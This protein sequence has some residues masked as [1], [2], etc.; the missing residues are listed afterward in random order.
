MKQLLFLGF[1]SLNFFSFGQTNTQPTTTAEPVH[2]EQ[3]SNGSR[4]TKKVTRNKPTPPSNS[5][6]KRG[7]NHNQKIIIT[8]LSMQ[9]LF[10]FAFLL[11]SSITRAQEKFE[12][13]NTGTKYST[14]QI[15]AA[16]KNADFCGSFYNTKR[17][18]IKLDDGAE[19][20]L[21]SGV[22]LEQEGLKLDSSCLLS[23]DITFY[24][25]SWGIAS[26]GFI[27]KAF[28]SDL[29]KSEKEYKHSHP[30]N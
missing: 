25:Y 23:D 6:E 4:I 30:T 9:R 17:N 1:I 26:N 10:I 27:T 13:Q 20:A 21:K 14:E 11:I 28:N 7:R 16:F 2:K 15:A 22:E 24:D 12:I 5:K 18:I 19:V 29:H 3:I 8:N